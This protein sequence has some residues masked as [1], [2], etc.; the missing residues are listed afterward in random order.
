MLAD[1]GKAIFPRCISLFVRVKDIER[2]IELF[3]VFHVA[4]N[5][6]RIHRWQPWTADH[7]V[8]VLARHTSAIFNY[9]IVDFFHSWL[10]FGTL[11]WIFDFHEWNHM[12]VAIAEMSCNGREQ[13]IFFDDNAKFR[14][15]LSQ[16]LWWNDQVINKRCG[17]LVFDF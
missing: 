16:A 3:D 11:F 12:E 2:I 13:L 4:E 10:E 5:R 15:K 14:Q 17:M 6:R 9:E 1:V 7:T 8:I